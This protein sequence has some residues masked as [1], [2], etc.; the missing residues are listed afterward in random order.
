M[1]KANRKS[2]VITGLQV[3]ELWAAAN[4]AEEIGRPL[5][6]FLTVHWDNQDGKGTVQE[7]NSRL[8]ICA[9]RWLDRRGQPLACVWVIERGILSGLHAH[10]MIHVPRKHLAGFTS[11]LPR[12]TGIEALPKDKWPDMKGKQHVLGY[13]REGV[14]QLKRVYDHGVG[15]RRYL[16]KGSA[17][18]R[19]RYGIRHLDQGTVIGKRCGTSNSLGR[20]AREHW[21]PAAVAA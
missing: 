6:A 4:H 19:Y 14:W 16:L 7:R 8:L 3:D 5:N 18:R 21:Q 17:D 1:A 20:T 13:G 11:M 9:R 15:L 12:W 10:N 2:E